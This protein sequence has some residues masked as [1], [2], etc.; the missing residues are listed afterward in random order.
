MRHIA[1]KME[2]M[3]M[4]TSSIFVCLV[5]TSVGKLRVYSKWF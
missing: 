1:G 2:S 4:I 3:S 5:S